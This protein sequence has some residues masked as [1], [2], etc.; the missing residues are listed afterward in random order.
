MY[1]LFCAPRPRHAHRPP[2]NSPTS[3]R[4]PAAA[5]YCTTDQDHLGIHDPNQPG[6]ALSWGHAASP[7]LAHWVIDASTC[8]P[9]PTTSPA[10]S[11]RPCSCSSPGSCPRLLPSLPLFSFS[12]LVFLHGPRS[13]CRS[14]SGRTSG[15][16]AATV[17]GCPPARPRWS[18]ASRSSSTRAAAATGSQPGRTLGSA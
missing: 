4:S 1:H 7:D 18:T 6:S 9:D 16:M 5:A 11:C 10:L 12:L 17:A 8:V 2:K 15:S 14:P 13:S 3:H